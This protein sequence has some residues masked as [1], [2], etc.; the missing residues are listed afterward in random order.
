MGILFFI[1]TFLLYSH[2]GTQLGCKTRAV[3]SVG[4]GRITATQL[5]S[6]KVIKIIMAGQISQ[7]GIRSD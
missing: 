7:R 1:N 2:S 5:L 4:S 3:L 6:L